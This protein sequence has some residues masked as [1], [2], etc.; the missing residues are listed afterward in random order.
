[1]R[2][3]VVW[4]LNEDESFMQINFFPKT[5]LKSHSVKRKVILGIGGNEGNVLRNFKK[6]AILLAKH[7]KLRLL[8]TSLIYKNPPFGYKDQPHFYN[9][10]LYLQTRLN[11]FEVL[12][13][14]KKIERRFGREHRFR[15]GPRTLDL[16]IIFYDKIKIRTKRLQVPHLEY[17]DRKSVLFPL[18]I[19][20][21]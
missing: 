17:K 3:K 2:E 19:L 6:V 1:M 10:I 5:F 20:E 21:G 14:C 15:N 7:T 13:L 9:S 18:Q 4:H 8:K 11:P 16:D 12:R